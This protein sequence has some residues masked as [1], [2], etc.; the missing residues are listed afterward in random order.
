M[1]EDQAFKFGECALGTL[2]PCILMVSMPNVKYNPILQRNISD[3][4]NDSIGKEFVEDVEGESSP[5]CKFQNHDHKFEWTR[6]QFS[7]QVLKLASQY[8]YNVEFSGVEGSG[9]EPAFAS[10]IAIFKRC[11]PS[12]GSWLDA[13]K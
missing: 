8:G 12:D 3:R 13:R 5:P 9:Q 7:D 10:Q 6:E 1:E 11:D 4:K 2:C